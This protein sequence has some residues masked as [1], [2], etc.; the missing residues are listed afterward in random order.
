MQKK[1]IK[2][3]FSIKNVILIKIP[4]GH[5]AK[6]KH[7]ELFKIKIVLL[8]QNRPIVLSAFNLDFTE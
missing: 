6:E 2:N 8:I 3:L 4:L 7:Y 5:N 1:S